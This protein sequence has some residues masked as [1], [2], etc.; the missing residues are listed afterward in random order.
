MTR[1]FTLFA[2]LPAVAFAA[3]LTLSAPSAAA[4]TEIATTATKAMKLENK[5]G[6]HRKGRMMMAPEECE[7]L[8]IMYPEEREEFCQAKREAV[9]S[10]S[11]RAGERRGGARLPSCSPS[12]GRRLPSLSTRAG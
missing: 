2:A 7:K 10:P 5:S 8:Q 1:F 9:K 3:G 12:S 4:E 11:E 6:K